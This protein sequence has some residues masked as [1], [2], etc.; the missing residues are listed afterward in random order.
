MTAPAWMEAVIGD[1]GRAAG[2]GGLSLGPSGAAALRF[3]TGAALRLEYTGSE[4][5]VAMTFPRGDLKR[6]LSFSHPK[7]AFGLRV[8]TG[9]LPKTGE[10]VAAVRLAERDVTLP[11]LNEAF[12]LLWRLAG[13]T[14]GASWA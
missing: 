13:E 14:G 6:L 7:A 9:I 2:L 8:R 5:V 1:F 12:S 10:S 11:H 3:E 4:L